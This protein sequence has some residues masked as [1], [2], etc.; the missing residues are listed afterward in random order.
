MKSRSFRRFVE[1]TDIFGFEREVKP[2]DGN[3]NLLNQPIE[4]FD[5]ELMM[6]YLSK[7]TIGAY[8]PALY[9]TNEIRWGTQPGAVKLEV[10]TGYTFFIKKLAMDKQ[11]NPRWVA[12]KAFQLNRNGF[13]GYEDAVAQEVFEAVKNVSE[14]NIEAP[15]EDYK[16][17][18]NLVDNL[19]DKIKRTSKQIFYPQGVK[20]IHEDAYI[21]MMGVKNQG[22]EARNQ[23]RIEQNQTM[24]TYDR[25]QGTI[26]ITNYNLLSPT[27][28]AHEFKINQSDLELYFMP[29]QE[30]DEITDCIAVHMRYY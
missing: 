29:T 14:S 18:Q 5:I 26:R 4:Q 30:R 27:G 21:I 2:E 22:L 6:D 19:Y 15:V 10:D 8:T 12:K 3:D 25:E 20:K 17:L 7:K 16:D 13:G 28:G 11:G 24:V 9:F 23:Q 1:A